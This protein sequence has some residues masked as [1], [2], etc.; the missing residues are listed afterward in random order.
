MM[1]NDEEKPMFHDFLGMSCTDA[2]AV[3]AK[4]AS[5]EAQASD[6]AGASSGAR[7]P[8]SAS[9]DLISEK[10]AANNF[11]GV[12]YHCLRSDL[13]GSEIS[14]RFLGRKRSSSDST[15]MGSTRDR[16]HQVGPDSVE[17]LRLMKMLRNEVG[18]EQLRGSH[19]D[20][21]FFGIQ[22]PRPSCTSSIILKPVIKSR[23]ELVV[24]S[25]ERSIPMN[26]GP[27]VNYSSRL[28]QAIPAE[29]IAS[30]RYHE[31]SLG[32]PLI[33]QPAADEGSR[34]GIKGSGI[35][36]VVYTTSKA[37]DRNPAGASPSSSRSKVNL[38]PHNTE[39]ESANPSSR[40]NLS[41]PSRQMT[42]FYAGQAHVFDDVHPSKADDIMA[43][44]GSSGGSWS[45]TYSPKLGM[46]LP[47]NEAYT[48]TGENESGINN[49]A[50]S[51]DM[52]CGLS[53]VGT[54]KQGSNPGVR[55][56]TAAIG[57]HQGSRPAID[58]RTVA[59]VAESDTKGKREV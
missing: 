14:N 16:M 4:R 2:A 1:A 20:E 37:A 38:G 8:V 5:A 44:A 17:S 3:F 35:A 58:T 18:G 57:S 50:F 27:M 30:N 24:S 42:I 26:V 22:P 51:R 7:G 45:T 6:S 55:I 13:S 29:K 12:Q 39:M 43:L 36:N 33:S 28:G 47:L 32:A 31:A 21:L 54:S 23:P 49:L 46:R 53:I 15:F 56:S 9:S 59:Q 19:D 40:C 41:S 10:Q 48:V 25:W 11:E 34:T 52:H